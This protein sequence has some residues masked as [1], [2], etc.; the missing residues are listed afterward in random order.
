M[1][2]IKGEQVNGHLPGNFIEPHLDFIC[3]EL[4]LEALPSCKMCTQLAHNWVHAE[5]I[6]SHNNRPHAIMAGY[7]AASFQ[8]VLFTLWHLM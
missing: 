2:F 7:I 3:S 8:L 5:V 6:A 1:A 4:T